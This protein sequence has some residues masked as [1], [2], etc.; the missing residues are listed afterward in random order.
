MDIIKCQCF[1]RV[2]MFLSVLKNDIVDCQ[3]KKTLQPRSF[4]DTHSASSIPNS[5][6]HN[7]KIISRSV[8][9]VL[10]SW[11]GYPTEQCSILETQTPSV[12]VSKRHEV[13]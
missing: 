13:R 2:P 3:L 10:D 4:G 12:D 1:V 8:V 7:E 11:A 9:D 6:F 5:T